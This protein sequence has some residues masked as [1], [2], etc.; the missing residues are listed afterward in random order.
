MATF[1]AEIKSK[2]G[3]LAYYNLCKNPKYAVYVGATPNNQ[4]LVLEWLD[5]ENATEGEEQ[6]RAWLQM[7]DDEETNTNV[8]TFQSI[9][10][11]LQRKWKGEDVQEYTGKTQRFQLHEMIFSSTKT[12]IVTGLPA[13]SSNEM[14]VIERMFEMMQKQNEFFLTKFSEIEEKI[15]ERMNEEEEEEEEE[16]AEISGK[17]KLLGAFGKLLERDGIQNGIE[18]GAMALIGKLS[19]MTKQPSEP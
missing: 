8:Y 3:V 7:I 17:D 4:N 13:S 11:I 2:D 14:A 9:D 5:D 16:P 6:L 18:M 12:P 19:G 15:N 1:K 10:K